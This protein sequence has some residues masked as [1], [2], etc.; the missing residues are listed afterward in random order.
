MRSAGDY[1]DVGPTGASERRNIVAE[2]LD[3][4]VQIVGI[5]S[6]DIDEDAIAKDVL[7]ILPIGPIRRDIVREIERFPVFDRTRIDLTSGLIPWL[8]GVSA[9]SALSIFAEGQSPREDIR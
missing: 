7:K 1:R 2:L 3:T 4:E 6:T 5:T 9:I 8:A